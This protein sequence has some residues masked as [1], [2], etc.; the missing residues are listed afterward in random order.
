LAP[1]PFGSIRRCFDRGRV[2]NIQRQDQGT[3]S[4]GPNFLCGGFKAIHT[5]GDQCHICPIEREG[6]YHRSANAGG[7]T[8]YHYHLTLK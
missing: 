6:T 1:I 8:G 4:A 2:G 3:S 7:S 5:A